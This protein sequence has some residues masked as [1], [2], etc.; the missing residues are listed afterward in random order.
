MREQKAAIFQPQQVAVDFILRRDPQRLAPGGPVILRE[1]QIHRRLARGRHPTLA[2][3]MQNGGFVALRANDR[4]A[5]PCPAIIIAAEVPRPV[6]F[7][8][9]ALGRIGELAAIARHVQGA[10]LP[11]LDVAKRNVVRP[12]LIRRRKLLDLRPRAT[13]ITAA[14]HPDAENIV[15]QQILFGTLRL[16]LIS[17]SRAE[18]QQVAILNL[19]G[20]DHLPACGCGLQRV[21]EQIGKGNSHSRHS[22]PVKPFVCF[23]SYTKCDPLLFSTHLKQT[24]HR[25]D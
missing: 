19:L 25:V 21:E 24:D 8:L 23:Y 3:E 12:P 7:G 1:I 13:A 11:L 17:P 22:R 9:C 5:F 6:A 4:R 16:L 20:H 14:A 10:V 15:T 18:N 2:T